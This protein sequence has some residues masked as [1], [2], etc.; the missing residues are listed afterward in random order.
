VAGQPQQN[1]RHERVHRTLKHETA[2]PPAAS[3]PTQQ[4]RFDAFR[5]VYNK[6]RPHEA[7]GRQTPAFL[8]RPSPRPYPNRVADPHYG[9]DVTVR[10]VRSTGQIKWAGELIF[11]G[12][13][14]TGELVG[15]R[16]TEGGDW[17]MRYADVELA[18]SIRSGAGSAR[19]HCGG[20]AWGFDGDRWRDPHNS[21]GPTTATFLMPNGSRCHPS[22]RFKASP[23]N[24]LAQPAQREGEGQCRA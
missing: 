21:T 8:Y 17:L 5:A 7:L 6:E 15:I 12:E 23:L 22:S 11:V 18:T 4:E 14:L 13:A 9:E 1:G 2:T 19:V 24:P 20:Q 10:R 3:L 16:E